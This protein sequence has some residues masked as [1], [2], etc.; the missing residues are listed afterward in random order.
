[1]SGFAVGSPDDKRREKY[2]SVYKK[3]SKIHF[4]RKPPTLHKA[5]SKNYV[6]TYLSPLPIV[7][8]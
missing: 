1:M 4:Y 8:N 7:H 5:T 2:E 3:I 6:V